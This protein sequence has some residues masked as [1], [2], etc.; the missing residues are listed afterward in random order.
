MFI[1][2]YVDDIIII[3]SSTT[4]TQTLIAPLNADFPLKDLGDLH[5]FLGIEVNKT[6]D[7]S[8]ISTK[9]YIRSPE[10]IMNGSVKS[11]A[12]SNG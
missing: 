4:E 8:P 10:E 1:L 9:I 2:V 12:Y 7:S 11:L 3:G 6:T 5:Y